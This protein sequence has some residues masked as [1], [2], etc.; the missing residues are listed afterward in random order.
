MD[1]KVSSNAAY[2][3]NAYDEISMIPNG[4]DFFIAIFFICFGVLSV[5]AGVGTNIYVQFIRD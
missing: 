2:E 1:N 3:T 4:T 5:I